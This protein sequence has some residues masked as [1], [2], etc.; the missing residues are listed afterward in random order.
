MI[1]VVD[2]VSYDHVDPVALCIPGR[3][4]AGGGQGGARADMKYQ[5]SNGGR[6]S[7]GRSVIMSFSVQAP[8]GDGLK[9]R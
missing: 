4:E 1:R 3:Q 6:D 7:M 5:S 2:Y 8:N 9:T